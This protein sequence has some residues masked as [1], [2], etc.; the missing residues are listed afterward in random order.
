MRCKNCG[1]E[2]D[3]NLYICQNCGSPLY[4]ENGEINSDKEQGTQV[5]GAV[6]NDENERLRQETMMRREER[7]AA[8][9]KKKK[10]EIAIIVVLVILLIAIIT[11]TVLAVVHAKKNKEETT[12]STETSTSDVVESTSETTTGASTTTTTSTTATTTTTTTQATTTVTQAQKCSVALSCEYGGEVEGDT[13][14]EKGK[15]VTVIAR[16][17]DGY[18]FAGWYNGSNLVSSNTVYTFTVNSDTNLRAAFIN[19]DDGKGPDDGSDT[20]NGADD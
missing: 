2:N 16:P 7:K 9:E 6:G 20:L 5:F 15:T 17:N 14:V 19:A 10:Q 4:D 18:D 8:A 13:T 3:D 1:C 12:L 11:G